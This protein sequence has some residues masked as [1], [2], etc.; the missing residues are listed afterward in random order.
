MIKIGDKV[1]VGKE[2]KI[3]EVYEETSSSGKKYLALRFWDEK[4]NRY[5]EWNGALEYYLKGFWGGIN[6]VV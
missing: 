5:T 2:K 1:S 4:L 6:S 3:M